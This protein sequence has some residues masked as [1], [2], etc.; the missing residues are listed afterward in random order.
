MYDLRQMTYWCC[1]P[2]MDSIALPCPDK[3]KMTDNTQLVH[4]YLPGKKLADLSLD[5]FIDK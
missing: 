3:A 1:M 4:L 5:G 2:C